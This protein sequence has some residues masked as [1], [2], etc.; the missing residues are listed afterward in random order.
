MS[1]LGHFLCLAIFSLSLAAVISGYRDDDPKQIIKG[2]PRRAGLFG[3]AVLALAWL[4][5]VF[6][7]SFLAV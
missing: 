1:L 2:I 6:G 5:W 3:S 4:A 7:I